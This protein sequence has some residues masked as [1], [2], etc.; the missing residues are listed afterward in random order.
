MEQPI[1][2]A[3]KERLEKAEG[4]P[5][6]FAELSEEELTALTQ[7]QADEL[8]SLFGYN[9]MILL[10]EREQQFFN[11]LQENDR[12]VWDDLWDAEDDK[13]YYV[14]MAHLASFLPGR[15]GFPICDL[16][17][18]ENYCFT[19]DE[20][21]ENDGSVYVENALDVI[22][23]KKQLAMEQAFAVEV[24]R[25][26]IDQWRFAWMYNLPLEEV[27]KMVRW[28]I[29][30]GILSVP[31]QRPENEPPIEVMPPS[32]GIASNEQE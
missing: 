1:Y 14:S 29:T 23:D 20:I 15:R 28:L 19:S 7:E 2:T 30:E 22:A 8:V 3:L 31:K 9:T 5:V 27:K 10:P 13:P 4:T 18:Q 16:V 25:G 6:A 21:T 12:L 32:N 11:W 26:P 24:W 17:N